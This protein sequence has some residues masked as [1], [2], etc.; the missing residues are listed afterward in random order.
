MIVWKNDA[1][2]PELAAW[3]TVNPAEKFVMLG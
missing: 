2:G 1:N 3:R